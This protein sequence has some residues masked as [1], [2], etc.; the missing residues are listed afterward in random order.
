[1]IEVLKNIFDFKNIYREFN[2]MK[3]FFPKVFMILWLI[4]FYGLIF[5]AVYSFFILMPSLYLNTEYTAFVRYFGLF[6]F[7][8]AV[9]FLILEPFG[10]FAEFLVRKGLIREKV[11]NWVVKLPL[12]PAFLLAGLFM[13]FLITF[14]F[15]GGSIGWLDIY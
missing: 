6:G 7:L 14:F 10:K 3:G 8:T 4:F 9:G 5:F 15:N 1:M 12:I 11:A 13:L 2:E